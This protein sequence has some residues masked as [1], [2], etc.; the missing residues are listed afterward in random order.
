[1]TYQCNVRWY[2]FDFYMLIWRT[3]YKG[4]V[5]RAE[6]SY[7]SLQFKILLETKKYMRYVQL[8]FK[9]SINYVITKLWN[10]AIV[11]YEDIMVVWHASFYIVLSQILHFVHDFNIER[12]GDWT[13]W[14][15]SADTMPPTKIHN[16]YN[17]PCQN[18]A[19]HVQN[20]I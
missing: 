13:L 1:M 2:L 3:V 5:L 7:Q 19:S 15:L 16:D 18:W 17:E 4:E 9:Q 10:I 11:L 20:I 12:L 14:L 6:G 8:N